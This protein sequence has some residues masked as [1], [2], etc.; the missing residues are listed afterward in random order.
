MF[1][2]VLHGWG[3]WYAMCGFRVGGVKFEGESNEMRVEAVSH[4]LCCNSNTFSKND[5]KPAETLTT[6]L[7]KL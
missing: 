3:C 2:W 4:A 1:V 7:G 5:A 6:T